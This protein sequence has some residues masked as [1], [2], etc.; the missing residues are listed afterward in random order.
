MSWKALFCELF[1]DAFDYDDALE[2]NKIIPSRGVDA[3]YD[4]IHT[5]GK[6]L[7]KRC[8]EYLKEQKKI[9]RAEV[10]FWGSGNNAFQ[11][12]VPDSA[13][14]RQVFTLLKVQDFNI[15]LFLSCILL[16][17]ADEEYV[18]SSQKKGFKRY[19]TSEIEEIR[20]NQIEFEDNQRK[21]LDGINARMM[22]K[23]GSYKRQWRKL[24]SVITQLDCL[25]SLHDYGHGISGES[26]F[27]EIITKSKKPIIRFEDGKHP[28]LM[29][30]SKGGDDL[31]IPND[32]NLDDKICIVTGAN[33][34]GKSTI[35]RQTGLL[36]ILA[37]IGC[38]VPAAEMSLTPVDRVFSRM[39]A[40]DKIME[41]EST[42]YVELSET[43]NI[44]KNAT[45]DSLVI[46][47]EL[48]R[49]TTTYDGRAIAKAVLQDLSEKKCRSL[50]STHYH[51]LTETL[52][53]GYWGIM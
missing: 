40:S 12:E 14:S 19:T 17:R 45:K 53:V 16:F 52:K 46:V 39:G 23:F 44:L 22:N 34:G 18:L 48:G 49:G 30:M 7:K 9:F 31:F 8:D 6:R 36:T 1:R 25:I 38:R 26:C 13:S 24:L 15:S 20:Q 47:D 29:S 2:N 42:F 51:E 3:D 43:A 50:F 5:E 32:V 35:M 21:C 37:Q 33:M 10:K 28:I 4:E 11:L 27:P 41:G